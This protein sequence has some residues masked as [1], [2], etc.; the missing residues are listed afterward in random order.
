MTPKKIEYCGCCDRLVCENHDH[1]SRLGADIN[2]CD[3]CME[4]DCKQGIFDQEYVWC[5][6]L[7]GPNQKIDYDEYNEDMPEFES[8]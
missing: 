8:L 6:F 4:K 3:S 5:W 7:N 2:I 1:F